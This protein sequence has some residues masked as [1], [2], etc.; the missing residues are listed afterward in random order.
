MENCKFTNGAA[1]HE[2]TVR[3]LYAIININVFCG[4]LVPRQLNTHKVYLKQVLVQVQINT[5]STTQTTISTTTIK[6]QGKL[7]SLIKW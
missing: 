4:W 3:K 5:K 7:P 1:I 6:N 2:T